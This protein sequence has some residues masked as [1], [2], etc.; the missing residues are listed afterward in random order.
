MRAWFDIYHAA[1]DM[2]I[3][4]KG[5][6]HSVILVNQWIENE[7]GRGI[8]T[9][10]IILAGFSQGAVI[11][12]H[13]GLRYP[14]RLGGV[15]ALSGA[16]PAADKVFMEKST[17]NTSI[18]IFIAHGSEDAVIP[19]QLG[20]ASA[21]LLK[22]N[23]YPTTWRSYPMPHTVCNEEIQDIAKWLTTTLK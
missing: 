12:L 19:L 15:L 22:T 14:K 18:P 1:L 7:I 11:A 10:K 13:A 3:D 23:G 6:A 9:D 5:I 8:P 20:E 2:Q 4:E 17:A 21:Q 16:L